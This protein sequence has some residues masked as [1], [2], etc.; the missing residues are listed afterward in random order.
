MN[1]PSNFCNGEYPIGCRVVIGPPYSENTT[2][3]PLPDQ[4]EMVKWGMFV[5]QERARTDAL[6][7][8]P[9]IPLAT[10]PFIPGQATWGLQSLDDST[11]AMNARQNLSSL[12]YNTHSLYG[13]FE[14]IATLR[15][16]V[17]LNQNRPFLLS[18]S[19]FVGS[20]KYTAHWTGDNSATWESMAVRFV[21][22]V[23]YVLVWT[24][25]SIFPLSQLADLDSA[26]SFILVVWYSDG[27]CRHLRFPSRHE[28]RAV[29]AL[30]AGAPGTASFSDIDSSY[31]QSYYIFSQFLCS[32][33]EFSILIYSARHAVSL[34]S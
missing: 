14:S 19:T 4:Q 7:A 22:R 28:C 10:P 9:P 13:Y 32:S 29:R 20:G 1:E 30:D 26:H 17:N 18:R 3:I 23:Q 33:A 24:L 34:L 25:S 27:W 15:A 21:F 8:S 2:D 11:L 5:L 6:P 31:S 12:H 16:L